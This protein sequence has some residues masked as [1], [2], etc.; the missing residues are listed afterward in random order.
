MEKR[1]AHHVSFIHAWEGI[2]W[3]FKT[4]P[5]FRIH[6]VFS[7]LAL[8]L[9]FFFAVSTIEYLVIIF[10]IILGLSVEMINTSIE[11]MTDL[12]TLEHRQ[13]AKVAKDVAAGMMLM[14]ALGA[15]VIG[16]VIFGPRVLDVITSL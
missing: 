8:F 10:T 1:S 5:N 12:I 11:S 9:C 6:I 7:L 16:C 14:T 15:F 13:D 4:Q 3:A 2:V